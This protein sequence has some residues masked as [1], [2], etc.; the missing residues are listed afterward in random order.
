MQAYV[1]GVPGA[2]VDLEMGATREAQWVAKAYVWL[3]L[4]TPRDISRGR[5]ASKAPFHRRRG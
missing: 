4:P 2:V 1:F 5:E 3:L